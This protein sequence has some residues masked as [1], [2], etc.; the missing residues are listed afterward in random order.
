MSLTIKQAFEAL[1]DAC[2]KGMKNPFFVMRRLKESFDDVASQVVDASGDKVTVTQ[3]V[4]EGTKIGSIKVNNNTTDLYAPQGGSS[5]Y[6]TDEHVVGTWIDG[7]PLY[8]KT[9][10]VDNI[11]I[12]YKPSEQIQTIIP[13]GITNFKEAVSL[14]YSSPFFNKTGSNV[15]YGGTS[16][17][18]LLAYF[19]VNSTNIEAAGGTDYHGAAEGRYWYFTL[20]YTKN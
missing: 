6:S 16:V 2:A 7:S 14:K 1:S 3:T 19:I 10:A 17:P 5:S 12:G 8:E 4:S 11:I 13:H 9:I 15:V 20:Q 18:S